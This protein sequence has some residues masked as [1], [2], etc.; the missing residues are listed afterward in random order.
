MTESEYAEIAAACDRLLRAPDMTLGRMSIPLLH[1]VDEHPAHLAQ[2]ASLL[3]ST[4]SRSTRNAGRSPRFAMR[5]GRA[6]ARSLKSTARLRKPARALGK[7]DVLIVSRRSGAGPADPGGVFGSDFYFGSMER[8]LQERG[9]RT[10]LVFVNDLADSIAPA[11]EAKI[12]RQCMDVRGQLRGIAHALPPLDSAVAALAARRALSGI[13]A[14]NLRLH[15]NLSQLCG[16]LQPHIVITTHEG[17][18]AERMIWNAARSGGRSPLCVGYQHTR[19]LQRAHAIRRS[20]QAPGVDCDPDVVLTL[21]EISHATLA[22]SPGLRDVN[23][24]LYGSHRRKAVGVVVPTS[25]RPG[26]CLVLPDGD[27]DECTVLFEFALTCARRMPEFTFSLR[28]HPLVDLQALRQR[29]GWL[30]NLPGNATFS[31]DRSLEQECE[32]ARY[33]LYRG[34]SAAIHAVLSGVK[35]IYLTQANE[36]PFDPLFELRD[37]HDTVS[38]PEEFLACTLAPDESEEAD[39][40]LRARTFCERYVAPVR[41]AALDELLNSRHSLRPSNSSSSAM[42][43]AK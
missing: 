34:S 10:A 9:A 5:A 6:L 13:T 20:I 1:F 35:P 16:Q 37:W 17:V 8:M 7:V 31:Q 12:W 42:S 38:S 30:R 41:P 15:A 36:L 21:G 4:S 3:P 27:A 19:L 11:D 43:S 32:T 28:P 29:Q 26:R 40:A 22:A 23:L 14:A 39:A 25:R 33:C 2:Y 24:L 18:A